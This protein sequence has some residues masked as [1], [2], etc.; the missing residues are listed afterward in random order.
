MELTQQRRVLLEEN[1]ASVNNTSFVYHSSSS[2][3]QNHIAVEEGNTYLCLKELEVLNTNLK[4]QRLFA[5]EQI[6]SS[7]AVVKKI[8]SYCIQVNT[9][10]KLRFYLHI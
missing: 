6:Q 3:V 8:H 1:K 7:S 10:R 2:Q 5:D 9:T 4:N